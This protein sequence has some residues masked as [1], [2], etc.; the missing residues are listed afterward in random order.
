MQESKIQNSELGI[1]RLR[2][3]RV[4]FTLIELLVSMTI[5]VIITLMVA[6]IF[7]QAGVAWDTGTRKAEKMMAGRA[8]ADYIAQ[9]LSKAV[10]DPNG[11]AFNAGGS[12]LSFFILDDA[13]AGVSAIRQVSI[14]NADLSD[15]ISNVKV[16]TVGDTPQGL[17]V[18]GLV[19]VKVSSNIFQTGFYFFNRD[20]SRL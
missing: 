7:Q 14:T 11:G 15:D 6:R 17:P 12:P 8:V 16:T 3:V 4:G 19:T 9:Q 5:L 13:S 18:Y 2:Q 10:P 1:A 20:R